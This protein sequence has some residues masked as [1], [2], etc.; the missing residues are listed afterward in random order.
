M[1]CY[2]REYREVRFNCLVGRLVGKIS[3]ARR[4]VFVRNSGYPV[5]ASE[6]KQS[7]TPRD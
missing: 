2:D 4:I 5:I 3:R 6:V 7:M 1:G